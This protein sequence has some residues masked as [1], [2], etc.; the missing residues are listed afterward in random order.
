[1]EGGGQLGEY[2]AS[3]SRSSSVVRDAG[4][5]L[6]AVA[7]E[8][9]CTVCIDLFTD[10]RMLPC[11]HTF[12]TQCLLKLGIT[13]S[14]MHP[15]TNKRRR[16]CGGHA[17]NAHSAEN[18]TSCLAREW[19]DSART[20]THNSNPDNTTRY[21]ANI[22]EKLK[23]SNHTEEKPAEL[24]FPYNLY[25]S[26]PPVSPTVPEVVQYCFDISNWI[27]LQFGSN[28]FVSSVY[29]PQNELETKYTPFLQQ[30]SAP[31]L[32]LDQEGI[33]CVVLFS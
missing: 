14:L 9:Q 31:P 27:P 3:R 28:P 12:C 16:R 26:A 20:G 4:G 18:P 17:S 10:P 11:G 15:N 24:P 23:E 30:P 19:K 33:S 1:M 32:E 8:L 29:N 22:V 13:L 7:E 5:V 2:T 21:I 25:T 6:S